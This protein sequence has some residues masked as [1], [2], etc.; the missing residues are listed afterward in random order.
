MKEIYNFI[1][2]LSSDYEKPTLQC[3]TTSLKKCYA[4]ATEI[5]NS[6]DNTA[7]SLKPKT[8]GTQTINGEGEHYSKRP[9]TPERKTYKESFSSSSES[10]SPPLCSHLWVPHTTSGSSSLKPVR[11]STSVAFD[12]ECSSSS[13]ESVN[14]EIKSASACSHSLV[15][16]TNSS[17][18]STRNGTPETSDYEWTST[19]SESLNE[20][21]KSAQ[22]CSY[23]LELNTTPSSSSSESTRNG[24]LATSGRNVGMKR[25]ECRSSDGDK[26]DQIGKVGSVKSNSRKGSRKERQNGNKSVR[27]RSQNSVKPKKTT[28][29]KSSSGADTIRN[30]QVSQKKSRAKLTKSLIMEPTTSPAQS[31]QKATTSSSSLPTVRT[32][33]NNSSSYRQSIWNISKKL[34]EDLDQSEEENFEKVDKS[35]SEISTLGYVSCLSDL[36]ARI[37][38]E[39]KC[40]LQGPV[41]KTRE[42]YN[43]IETI[44]NEK[45]NVCDAYLHE[46]PR[47]SSSAISSI[48]TEVI[49][50]T[51]NDIPDKPRNTTSN[52]TEKDCI[53]SSL[54]EE[55]SSNF[56][57]TAKLNSL[58]KARDSQIVVEQTSSNDQQRRPLRV[59]SLSS[60]QGSLDIPILLNSTVLAEIVDRVIEKTSAELMANVKM[61]SI[62]SQDVPHDE[63]VRE[64]VTDVL[65]SVLSDVNTE[66]SKSGSSVVDCHVSDTALFKHRKG[67]TRTEETGT[68]TQS[69]TS[70][71]DTN[72]GDTDKAKGVKKRISQA[73]ENVAMKL[74]KKNL[75]KA[76][77]QWIKEKTSGCCCCPSFRK[78]RST[79]MNDAEEPVDVIEESLSGGGWT[80]SG[81]SVTI[82]DR[83]T[84]G[85]RRTPSNVTLSSSTSSDPP[86]EIKRSKPKFRRKKKSNPRGKS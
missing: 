60:S 85:S 71:L 63:I 9:T 29:R 51:S 7:E 4:E 39:S 43:V 48:I 26:F 35:T 78:C 80:S 54:V 40:S 18:E 12:N 21:I 34:T 33:L 10:E 53:N 42:K 16:S 3:D 69:A 73:L 59:S 22:S 2:S 65:R 86:P 11:K 83:R 41:T 6:D 61:S 32:T 27:K 74:A 24:T 56:P 38:Q 46:L 44:N 67:D 55:E 25:N 75:M 70:K 8:T 20:K 31:N 57:L 15:Q 30:G 13:S 62:P 49:Q 28:V 19:S 82:L 45:S 5:R 68:H 17:S 72:K 14:E 79:K 77:T 64:I 58:N 52:Y 1:K 76:C 47:S 50:K 37:L 36:I 84:P 81:S 23:S 66:L